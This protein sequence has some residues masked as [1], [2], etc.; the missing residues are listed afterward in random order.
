VTAAWPYIRLPAYTAFSPHGALDHALVYGL[1]PL[2]LEI[3]LRRGVLFG[4]ARTALASAAEFSSSISTMVATGTH[5]RFLSQVVIAAGGIA[6]VPTT[7]SWSPSFWTVGFSRVS[8]PL[9]S[10]VRIITQLP[11]ISLGTGGG[12][13][14]G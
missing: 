9:G 14:L 6:I 2:A 10:L 1:V 4:I 7:K 8:K 13:T 12:E 11:A 5:I 3:G